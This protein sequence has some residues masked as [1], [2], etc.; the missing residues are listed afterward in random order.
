LRLT[1]NRVTEIAEQCGFNSIYSFSRAFRA[2][3]GQS[4]VGYRQSVGPHGGPRR[5]R[6]PR[7]PAIAAVRARSRR[8]P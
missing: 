5:H 4:P 8:R 2:A 6:P 3:F 1:P 7:S